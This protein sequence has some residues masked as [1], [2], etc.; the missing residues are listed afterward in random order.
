M[1][2]GRSFWLPFGIAALCVS[3]VVLLW[4]ALIFQFHR[5]EDAALDQAR[6]DAKNLAMAFGEHVGRTIGAI[7]QLILTIIAERINHPN[8]YS[9]PTW[10]DSS[11]LLKGMA[12]QVSV[13]GPDGV[14]RSSNLGISSEVDMSDRPHFRHHLDPSAPQPYIS[15]PV[16][17]RISRKWSIQVT[18]RINEGDGS[19]GGVVVVSV[20][21]L[22]FVR[23]YDSVELGTS[24]TVLLVGDDGIVRARRPLDGR[25]LGQD[26]GDGALL[27]HSRDAK[28]GAYL[29]PGK[30]DGIERLFGY[31]SIADYPLLVSVGIGTNDILA[32]VR[33]ERR[34]GLAL[35]AA[36]T[37]ILIGLSW[38][39]I[40][41]TNRRRSRADELIWR[42]KLQMDAA[43]NNMSQGLALFDG[44]ARLVLCNQRYIEMYGLPPGAVKP[45]C[46]LADILALRRQAGNFADDPEQYCADV[47][48]V[49]GRGRR[50]HHIAETA[51][52]RTIQIVND[53]V[54]G[55]GWVATHEDITSRQNAEKALREARLEAEAAEQHARS[56]HARLLDAFEVVPEGLVLFDAD[57]R[58]VLWNRRYAEMSAEMGAE[59]SAGLRFEDILRSNLARGQFADAVGR[60]EEW[61]AE[62]LALHGR[63]QTT[64]EQRLPDGRWV[65]IHER[66]TADGGSVKVRID[67]TELKQREESFRLLF[68]GNP[69]P[70][71]VYDRDSL[72]FLDVNAAAIVHYGYSRAE[73]LAMTLLD[74]RPA[75]DRELVRALAGTGQGDYLSG[76]TWRHLKASGERIDAA[77]FSQALVYQG[78]SASLVAI[79]D[80]TERKS[81]EDELRRTR[82]FLH[83]ILD[84]IPATVLVK[85]AGDLCY[86]LVN[87]SGEKLLGLP[88]EQILGK[89]AQDVLPPD[90]AEGVGREDQK[91]LQTRRALSAP[92]QVIQTSAGSRIVRATKVPILDDDGAT[93]FV[94]TVIDDLTE[95]KQIERQLQQAQ[96][97]EAVGNL[98]GGLA[99]DFN[100]LLMIIIG[101][102]DLLQEEVTGNSAAAEMVQT[103]LDASLRGAELTRQLLAF[104]R[105]QPL[106][107]KIVELEEL[108]GDTVRLL[109]RT[110][111]EDIRV[112]LDTGSALPPVRV[113]AAQLEAALVNM[114]INA[115][116]AM[117]R[118]GTLRIA[119]E[120]AA[121]GAEDAASYPEIAPGQYTVISI[122]DTGEGMSPEVLARV[123]EPFF[124]TK[125][126][127]EG[128]GLGLSMVYGFMKQ[129]G[130]HVT[131]YSEV[132]RGTTFRLYLPSALPASGHAST[133]AAAP[134]P[135][136]AGGEVILAVDDNP[137][138]RTTVT[139][140]L[141]DLGYQVITA[142][143][144]DGAL[145]TIKSSSRI[146]LLFT[147]VVMPGGMDGKA[148][149]DVARKVRPDLKVLFTSGFPGT[150]IGDAVQFDGGE[151]FLSKPYR[152]HDL[153]R[154]VREVLE[155]S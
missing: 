99:H 141:R 43:L 6:K 2:R 44:A 121:F 3:V 26:I 19:F 85:N 104:S 15:A 115:R 124:T 28:A 45:G 55:G 49:I 60:E 146:D 87:K 120:P 95:R 116:D 65:K 50:V 77:V 71:W 133:V 12:L 11:P 57:D 153:A 92:E 79:V 105:R 48:F 84:N 102:L 135:P 130:G 1:L 22:Y 46:T 5:S 150:S 152:K 112:E 139:R 74:I 4:A 154:K 148:L 144:A 35:G 140:H 68:E 83:T 137:D 52:G 82:A 42:Q 23:F 136:A 66:R 14:A 110:L 7:D 117:P 24:G 51:D 53:P 13:L 47:V 106:Q 109:T 80:I 63:P 62:R 103:T 94:L 89:T 64:L 75:E 33:R 30:S 145:D 16:M 142:D 39:L 10:L 88:R 123:F 149:A 155:A 81:V 97:M 113:D 20:D 114:A 128:T 34:I 98:T 134:M 111:G 86:V 70:M 108:V 69:L 37:L 38:L 56:A 119:I 125:S 8:N 73:F 41:A 122:S 40:R 90:T 76:R 36:L 27:A 151:A 18:R 143:G 101:N 138:V 91:I 93:Q 9:L 129:S 132:G 21:P 96:K 147:D 100:N 118:G 67:I 32:S 72:R 78:A 54:A 126:P 58:Y 127:G 131:V 29:A 61:I 59:P 107:P 17:G 25:G 31:M